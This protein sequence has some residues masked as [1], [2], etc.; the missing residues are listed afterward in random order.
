MIDT[1]V[2][3]R[4]HRAGVYVGA[5]A[6]FDA[7]AKTATMTG[8]RKIWYWSGAASVDGIAVR[9][10]DRAKS[11]VCAAVE[12]VHLLDVVQVIACTS[13]GAESVLGA[14]EWRP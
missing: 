8:A 13:D 14:P 10:I 3:I 9:G 2:L 4:D 5:L 6:A 1:I 11:K 12:Q 7:A